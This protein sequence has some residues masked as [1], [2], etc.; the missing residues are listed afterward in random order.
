MS[1]GLSATA[2]VASATKFESLVGPLVSADVVSALGGAFSRYEADFNKYSNL[3]WE[4]AGASWESANYYDRAFI[5]YTWY[6][7][8]GD[9][10]Y[11]NR[12]NALAEDYLLNYVEENQY[13]VAS[14]WSMPKGITAH[15]LLNGDKASL[16]AIGKMADGVCSPWNSNSNWSNLFDPTFS[17][18][19]EIARALETLTQAVLVQAPSAGFETRPGGNDFPAKAKSLVE[20]ILTTMQL[21]DGSRPRFASGTDFEGKAVDKPFMN[22][23]VNEA[24]INYY[25]QV[26]ADPRIVPFIKANL[27]YMWAN[28]WDA[29][30]KAFQYVD[31]NV[32]SGDTDDPAPDLNGLIGTGFGFVYQH[33]GDAT[34]LSRGDQVFAGGVEG[35]WLTGSKQFNQEYAYSLNYLGYTQGDPPAAAATSLPAKTQPIATIDSA[36]DQSLGIAYIPLLLPT[37]IASSNEHVANEA[38][39]TLFASAPDIFA[40]G[41]VAAT[42][43][44]VIMG[45]EKGIDLIDLSGIDAQRRVSGNQAFTLVDSKRFTGEGQIRITWDDDSTQVL[46]NISGRKGPE[47]VLDI[48]G[49]HALQAGDFIC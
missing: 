47:L 45:F 16:T 11:L 5:N 22:G 8:T 18:G 43:G 27:D 1:G 30:A 33:T 49:H 26:E 32:T 35:A 12:G 38:P 37:A 2:G 34:Y 42:R 31:K 3:H 23:L 39:E 19:R 6:A 41:S 17:E 7:R 46:G 25:E 28:E 20:K 29:T 14:W 40:F 10:T 4:S 36:P 21:P 24:L 15:Y 9:V 44:E 13:G 48:M